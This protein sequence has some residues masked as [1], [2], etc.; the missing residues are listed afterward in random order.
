MDYMS[1]RVLY[2]FLAYSQTEIGIFEANQLVY[3]LIVSLGCL[4]AFVRTFVTSVT[5]KEA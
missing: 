2:A 3:G 5:V 1:V 4:D